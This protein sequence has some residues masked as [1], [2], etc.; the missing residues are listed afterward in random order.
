MNDKALKL[1]R[2]INEHITVDDLM[3]VFDIPNYSSVWDDGH[4]ITFCPIHHD[5]TYPTLS[6]DTYSHTFKCECPQC[7]GHRGGDLLDLYCMG[8]NYF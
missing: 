2:E 1:V 6:I 8:T 5:R 3:E 7:N 4:M